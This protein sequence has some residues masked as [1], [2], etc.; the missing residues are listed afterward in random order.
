MGTTADFAKMYP[1]LYPELMA[2]AIS[3]GIPSS[4]ADDVLQDASMVA[5]KNIESFQTGTNFRAWAYAIVRNRVWSHLKKISK[6]PLP[7]PDE[8]LEK[9]ESISLA[10]TGTMETMMRALDSCVEK[11]QDKSRA[12]IMLRYAD[13]KSIEEIGA[14]LNKTADAIYQILTRV[15]KSLQDCISRHSAAQELS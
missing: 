15:R 14:K 4:E 5:M 2:Y 9:I 12:V 3:M 10:D 13:G 8:T 6:R 11:L 1:P 7:L